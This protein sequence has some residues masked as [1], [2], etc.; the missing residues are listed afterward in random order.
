M[1]YTRR[2]IGAMQFNVDIETPLQPVTT[3]TGTRLLRR[4]D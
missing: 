4:A 2:T 3:A 1:Y